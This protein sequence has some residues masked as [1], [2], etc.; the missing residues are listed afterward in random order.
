MHCN[1]LS[2]LWK[3][4]WL[5]LDGFHA[6]ALQDAFSLGLHLHLCP[7]V[8]L[9]NNVI[10][11]ICLK[12]FMWLDLY[13]VMTVCRSGR[14][15]RRIFIIWGSK[16]ISSIRSASSSTFSQ[17]SEQ[18]IKNNQSVL[19]HTTLR[20]HTHTK[21]STNQSCKSLCS[22]TQDLQNFKNRVRH[23]CINTVRH[24]ERLSKKKKSL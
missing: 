10:T 13:L 5:I 9:I 4:H 2:K 16:P 3:K 22:T 24:F 7:N 20:K 19:P 21:H 6:Q 1:T 17:W 8:L 15:S 14:M 18:V 23:K 11:N 12:C